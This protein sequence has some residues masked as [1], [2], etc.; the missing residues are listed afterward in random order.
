MKKKA[1]GISITT[2]IVAAIALIVLVVLIAVFTGRMGIFGRD[3][4]T[5]QDGSLCTGSNMQKVTGSDCSSLGADWEITYSN[6][7][8][9]ENGAPTCC[10]DTNE[11]CCI[12]KSG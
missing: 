11:Y 7:K 1:Q 2:I 5:A 12:K 9:C 3:L 6:F 4:T 10:L 8:K